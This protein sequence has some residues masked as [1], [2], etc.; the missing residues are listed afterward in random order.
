[1]EGLKM[2]NEC[3]DPGLLVCQALLRDSKLGQAVIEVVDRNG[4]IT[5][6]GSVENEQVSVS[7]EAVALEQD[8]VVQVINVL[9]VGDR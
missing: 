9:T 4:T 5:L 1:M 6:K 3:N 8:G 7:A 2:Q